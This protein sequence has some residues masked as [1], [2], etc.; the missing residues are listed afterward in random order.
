MSR[1]HDPDDPVIYGRRTFGSW[2]KGWP[3]R[4]VIA[5]V[6]LFVF[7]LVVTW[8]DQHWYWFHMLF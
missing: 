5:L 3:L 6:A 1:K 7:A 8:L 4:V 2:F